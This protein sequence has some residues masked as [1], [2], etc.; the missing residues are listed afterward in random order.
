V[1][2]HLTNICGIEIEVVVLFNPQIRH[3]DMFVDIETG[4]FERLLCTGDRAPIDC[5]QDFA[6][7]GWFDHPRDMPP[8]AGQAEIPADAI[9]GKLN[10]RLIADLADIGAARTRKN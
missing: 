10:G 6:C 1:I 3:L 7:P 5:N 9:P 4:M 8:D 2:R